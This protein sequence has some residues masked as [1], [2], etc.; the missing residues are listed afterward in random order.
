[1]HSW[2][3]EFFSLKISQNLGEK[4]IYETNNLNMTWRMPQN[5]RELWSTPF[6]GA[7][8]ASQN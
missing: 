8:E 2:E 7:K 3:L 5:I 1:M 4:N 6:D